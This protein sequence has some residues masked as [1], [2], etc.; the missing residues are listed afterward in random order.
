MPLRTSA[1]G[2]G[3]RQAPCRQASHISSQEASNA[4]DRP[5]ST[6]SSGP[7]GSSA[8][9]SRASASTNAAAE[10]CVTATP[11][12]LPVEPEVKMIHASSS[13]PGGPT[14]SRGVPRSTSSRPAPRTAQTPASAKTSSARS[15]RIL[16]VD[17]HVGRAGRQ[18]AED[19]DVEVDRAGRDPHTDPVTGA[20]AGRGEPAAQLVDLGA[21]RAVG[22]HGVAVVDGGRAG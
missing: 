10:R 14:S 18:H 13:R 22:Q 6:R 12:G 20:D 3:T 4:T 19:R 8:R 1:R 2:A 16:G 17:R 5:A 11:L 7:I 15:S 21:E 9:N